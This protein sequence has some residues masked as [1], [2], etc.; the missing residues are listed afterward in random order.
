MFM[1]PDR[2]DRI[3]TLRF[4]RSGYESTLS[5][6]L[7]SKRDAAARICRLLFRRDPLIMRLSADRHLSYLGVLVFC[8]DSFLIPRDALRDQLV[9]LSPQMHQHLIVFEVPDLLV[10]LLQIHRRRTAP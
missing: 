3:A 9:Q 10:L 4:S 1:F 2:V 8:L 7:V 5:F 6:P